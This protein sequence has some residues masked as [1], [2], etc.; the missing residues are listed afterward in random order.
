MEMV[1]GKP[2]PNCNLFFQMTMLQTLQKLLTGQ[3]LLSV[4]YLT[5]S[6]LQLREFY[7]LYF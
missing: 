6:L 2:N 4:P 1:Q 5:Y 3:C 7:N